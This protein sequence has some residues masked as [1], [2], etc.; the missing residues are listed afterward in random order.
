MHRHSWTPTW[1][2]CFADKKQT[3]N[4][5]CQFLP[6]EEGEWVR[7]DVFRGNG[8]PETNESFQLQV[9]GCWVILSQLLWCMK[10]SLDYLQQLWNGLWGPRSYEPQAV[11]GICHARCSSPHSL[12]LGASEHRLSVCTV[13]CF[14]VCPVPGA[15]APWEARA[16]HFHFVASFML[17]HC[18][19]YRG[20]LK[21]CWECDANNCTNERNIKL[22]QMSSQKMREWWSCLL[23]R[24]QLWRPDWSDP[25]DTHILI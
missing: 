17:A 19:T 5:A 11:C 24:G 13:S 21:K 12:G 18:F 7:M 16:G 4:S 23:K 6:L 8:V 3:E 1:L 15:W 22:L 20:S 14:C 9:L 10:F 2:I 25:I